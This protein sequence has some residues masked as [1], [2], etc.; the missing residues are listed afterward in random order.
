MHGVSTCCWSAQSSPRPFLKLLLLLVYVVSGLESTARTRD[1]IED[2]RIEVGI[3][4]FD[5]L[6]NTIDFFQLIQ[7]GDCS[8]ERCAVREVTERK[9]NSVAFV[10]PLRRANDSAIR[11]EPTSS[12]IRAPDERDPVSSLVKSQTIPARDQQILG[13]TGALMPVGGRQIISLDLT[14]KVL[15]SASSAM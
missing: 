7:G 11:G 15:K 2:D 13:N 1:V 4:T 12:M 5:I 14:T 10:M 9:P 8:D 6:K 3:E